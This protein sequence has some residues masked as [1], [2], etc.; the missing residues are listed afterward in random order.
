MSEGFDLPGL[1]A[2]VAA[3]GIVVRVVVAG[4]AGSAPRET[5]AAMLVWDAGQSG[6]IGGG[7]LEWQAAR[8]ARALLGAPGPWARQLLK[9]PLGPALGQCCGGH[10]TLLFER[11]AAEELASLTGPV[12]VR[13]VAA[14]L[15]PGAGLAAARARRAA[16]SGDSA[17]ARMAD[18]L[19]IEPLPEPAQP[20]WLY[21]AGHV[22]RAI[23]RVAEDLPLAIT[24]IDSARGRFPETVPAHAAPLVAADPARAALHAPETAAHLVLTYSHA[25]DLG[26]C[27]AVLARRFRY[28]GLIGSA[29][30]AARFRKRLRDL[31]HAEPAIAR[32][33]CPIGDRTLGKRPAA[34]ALGVVAEMLRLV[35]AEA[36]ALARPG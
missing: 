31:G 36:P 35:Q 4:F 18:G 11:Y 10:V 6:T 27:H 12:I 28:L 30:K 1:A 24:W 2:A 9:L 3:R 15:A 32:L 13:P 7:A 25:L 8:A 17:G 16:R 20:L 34:I 14:G 29:S 21:G 33:T 22:G 5:G 26:I 19:M 23:V